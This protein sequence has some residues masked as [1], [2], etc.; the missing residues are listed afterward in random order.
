MAATA[1]EGKEP[2]IL[3]WGDGDEALALIRASATRPRDDHGI[4]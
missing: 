1:L 3:G 4:R 2:R